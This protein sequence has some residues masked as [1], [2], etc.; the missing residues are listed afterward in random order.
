[1]YTAKRQL[2]L[3]GSRGGNDHAATGKSQHQGLPL[4]IGTKD[5]RQ[6][7]SGGPTGPRTQPRG[8]PAGGSGLCGCRHLGLSRNGSQPAEV[9]GYAAMHGLHVEALQA[10]CYRANLTVADRVAIPAR[11]GGDLRP[12]P[13]RKI[14]SAT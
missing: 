5:F 13:H 12:V 9:L 10:A 1:M 4:E 14:S 3:S 7:D 2:Q 6:G 8:K 11:D